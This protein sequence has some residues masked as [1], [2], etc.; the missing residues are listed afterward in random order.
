MGNAT[1]NILTISTIHSTKGFDYACVFLVGL[2]LL[3]E[4]GWSKEQIRNMTYVAITRARYQL[5]VP[6]IK[7]CSL[8]NRLLKSL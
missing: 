6:Y 2:D 7:E 8:I 3:E 4:N 1:T 5:F